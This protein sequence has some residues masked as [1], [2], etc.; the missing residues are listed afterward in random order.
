[1]LEKIKETAEYLQS[2]TSVK[3]SVGI[4]LGTGGS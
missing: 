2:R 4:I 3:P 1:M